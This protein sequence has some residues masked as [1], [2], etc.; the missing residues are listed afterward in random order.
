MATK[1][2]FPDLSRTTAAPLSDPQPEAEKA[3]FTNFTQE[4]TTKMIL[5]HP[6]PGTPES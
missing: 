1:C 6:L 4:Q 5:L 2:I 3:R